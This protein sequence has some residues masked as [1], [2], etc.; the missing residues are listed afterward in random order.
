MGGIDKM[1]GFQPQTK[2]SKNIHNPP[3]TNLKHIQTQVTILGAGPAG[4]VLGLLLQKE[5]VDCV[6]VERQSRTYIESRARAGLI[7]HHIVEF[8][9]QHDFSDGL[10]SKGVPHTTCEFRHEGHRYKIP[11]GTV[12]GGSHYVYPQQL[13]VQDLL[14]LFIS[15]GGTVFFSQPASQIKGLETNR[16]IVISHS[17]ASDAFLEIECDFVA[18]C[19]GFHGISRSSIPQNQVTVFSKQYGVGWLAIL[20]KVPS[21]TEKLVYA[22]H[23]SGF[24][25]QMP[26]TTEITRFYL[27]CP[28]DDTI[29]N[30]TDDRIWK[31]LNKRLSVETN[32]RLIQ[33]P[34]IEKRILNM[35]SVVMEPMNFG[36]L[37]LAGDAAHIITP[38]GAKGMNLAIADS[39]ILAQAFIHYYQNQDESL[40]NNYSQS[41][42]P[43]IWETQEFSD[44]MLRLIHN[45]S[46]T[47]E[48]KYQAF[49]D[50]LRQA[51]LKKIQQNESF[52][53]LFAESYVGYLKP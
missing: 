33:G 49:S 15:R 36:R 6:I 3:D 13:V 44:W 23:K 27:E 22:L 24:A 47:G 52:S 48:N 29:S 39:D 8:L 25:G 19:D 30:W 43:H 41:R 18:G 11:Y 40:L 21:S 53:K 42:L 28:P 10:D 26:R 35:R 4:L 31:E 32:D 5:G 17:S 45:V 34:I 9:R 51:R 37:F 50:R 46:D 38:V 12:A 20:A 1:K 14:K 7:E 16:P 2:E